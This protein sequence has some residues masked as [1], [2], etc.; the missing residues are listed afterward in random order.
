MNPKTRMT[1]YHRIGFTLVELLVVFA[2]IAILSALTVVAVFKVIGVQQH[3]NTELTVKTVSSLL[4]KHWA[5]V[6]NQNKNSQIPAKVMAIAANDPRRAQVIWNKLKLK[7][8]FPMN[9]TEALNP[10][11]LPPAFQTVSTAGMF[12]LQP[13]DLPA[14]PGYLAALTRASQLPNSVFTRNT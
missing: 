3:S 7:Q 5:A 1:G 2:I 6:L 11:S 4:D 13:N 9:L 14:K 10:S 8:E 12:A